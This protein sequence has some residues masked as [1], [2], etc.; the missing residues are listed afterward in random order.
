[1]RMERFVPSTSLDLKSKIVRA[2]A[3][4]GKTRELTKQVLEVVKQVL[5]DSGVAPRLVVT[6]FTRKATQELRERLMQEAIRQED[7]RLLEYVS[8][9]SPL[10]I[11]TI[12]GVLSLFLTR[13]ATEINIDPAFQILSSRDLQRL[14]KRTLRSLLIQNEDGQSLLESYSFTQ[15]LQ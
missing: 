5:Q 6:T 13:F 9:R 2:G 12:H 8:S 7:P 4:A 15:L 3:G 10:M 1:M 14:A 11:S